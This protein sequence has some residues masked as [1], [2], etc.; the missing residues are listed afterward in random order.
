V[1]EIDMKSF[2]GII[3]SL[4]PMSG[5]VINWTSPTDPDRALQFR[6]GGHADVERA[7]SAA[8]RAASLW[9][10]L[11]PSERRMA[12]LRWGDAIEAAAERIGMLDC[13]DMGKPIAVAMMEACVAAH[14][15]RWYAQTIDKACGE[16][17]AS[18][19]EAI[20][21]SLRVPYGVVGAMVSWNYPSINAAMKVGPALAAGNGMVLKPSE[22]SPRSAILIGTL[23]EEAG[24]PVGLLSVL[25]GGATTGAALCSNPGVA[26]LAF[27]GSTQ[28]GRSVAKLAAERLVPAI[29]EA[30]GK[31]AIVV[32]DDMTDYQG[33]A[34]DAVAE[35][36]ANSGQLCV[37]RSKILVPSDRIDQF[38]DALVAAAANFLPGDPLDPNTKFGPLASKAHSDRIRSAVDMALDRGEQVIRDGRPVR[39]DMLH[40]S[41]T[42]VRADDP[43]SPIL[44]DEYFGPILAVVPYDGISDAVRL[45]GLGGYGLAMTLWTGELARANMLRQ[46]LCVGH[47]KIKSVA[48]Q[49]SATGLALPLEPAGQSGYGI[50]FGVDALS[51]YSRRM[52]VEQIGCL[53]PLDP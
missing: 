41:L 39:H 31:N 11:A 47:L 17:I 35:A 2:D 3:G 15:V 32:L 53:A 6:A 30:G 33:I 43:T 51:S 48:G 45:A 28:T 38:A 9:H 36:Y 8:G 26:M 20:S 7:V 5:E 29:I 23:A 46:E 14:I 52:A 1:T 16:V 4:T 44:R 40:H 24:I 22:I 25:P 18:S 19:R 37:A 10:R 49:D 13:V 42:V 50:E 21:L 34:I 27:T 12:M